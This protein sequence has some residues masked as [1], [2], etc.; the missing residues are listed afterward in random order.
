LIGLNAPAVTVFPPFLNSV[1]MVSPSEGWIVGS[2]IPSTGPLLG[3]PLATILHFAPFGGQ[4]S[5]TATVTQTV[6][7]S[8]VAVTTTISSII[9]PKCPPNVTATLKMVDSQGNPIEGVTAV[10]T[11][12]AFTPCLSA[13]VEGVTNAQGT[14]TFTLPPGT[15]TVAVSKGS[16]SSTQTITISTSGGVFT[17]TLNISPGGLIPGFPLE[18]ILAGIALGTSALV[19]LR[20]RRHVR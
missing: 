20:R 14:V 3:F 13:S 17:I 9:V 5:A 6:S 12:A 19:L 2:P 11:P 10:L 7:T 18:S 15:Y 8:T 16:F 4:L 1:Y